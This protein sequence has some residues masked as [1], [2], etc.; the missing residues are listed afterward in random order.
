MQQSDPL[1][2]RK[3]FTKAAPALSKPSASSNDS[4]ASRYA[5]RRPRRTTAPSSRSPAPSSLSNPSTQPSLTGVRLDHGTD[6]DGGRRADGL[7][8]TRL[9]S[10]PEQVAIGAAPAGGLFAAAGRGAAKEDPDGGQSTTAFCGPTCGRQTHS[11]SK[12]GD[13]TPNPFV[14]GHRRVRDGIN[15]ASFLR[16]LVEHSEALAQGLVWPVSKPNVR[17]RLRL[18]QGWTDQADQ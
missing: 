11:F 6:A 16:A 18:F 8:R 10:S 1:S 9:E 3:F 4:S 15:S 14:L 2:Y 5:A 13:V 7:H 17:C 12:W